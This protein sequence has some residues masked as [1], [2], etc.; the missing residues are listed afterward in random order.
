MNEPATAPIEEMERL[1]YRLALYRTPQELA[2]YIAML[3][4]VALGLD[5]LRG[6]LLRGDARKPRRRR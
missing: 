5:L 6:D 2:A 3:R 4:E 1:L